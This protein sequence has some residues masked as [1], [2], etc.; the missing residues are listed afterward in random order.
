ML[1]LL[2]VLRGKEYNFQVEQIF[3]DFLFLHLQDNS[4][5]KYINGKENTV[6]N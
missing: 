1:L 5:T 2:K 3:I 6:D 4:G